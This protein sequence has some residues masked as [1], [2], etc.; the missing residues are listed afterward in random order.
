MSEEDQIRGIITH[1]CLIHSDTRETSFNIEAR[2]IML[3]LEDHGYVITKKDDAVDFY[4]WTQDRL[5]EQSL[6][7]RKLQG[8]SITPEKGEG[9]SRKVYEASV[10]S[11][12][13]N[14]FKQR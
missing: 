4:L 12:Y 1:A 10:R 11:M 8:I 5:A 13:H 7:V 9:L 14:E 2:R 3:A 6:A